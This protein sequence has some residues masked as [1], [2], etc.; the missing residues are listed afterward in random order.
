VPGEREAPAGNAHPPRAP[1][2]AATADA[3]NRPRRELDMLS[4]CDELRQRAGP[5]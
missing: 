1:P 3:A 2:A 5:V 4:P